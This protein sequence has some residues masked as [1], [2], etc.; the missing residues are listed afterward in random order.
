MIP[1]IFLPEVLTANLKR[2]ILWLLERQPS[3]LSLF[4]TAD[5]GWW[6][7][8]RRHRLFPLLYVRLLSAGLVEGVPKAV[9]QLLRHDY[10]AALH[11]FLGQERESRRLL[12]KLGDKGIEAI[13]LK[14]ADLRLRLYKDPAT[15]PMGDLDLLVS[16]VSLGAVRNLLGNLGYTLLL[17]RVNPRIGFGER[18]RVGLHFQASPPA[19]LMVDLHWG[20]EGVA[21][22]YRLPWARLAAQAQILDWEGI[23]FKVLSPEH[24]FMHLCLHHYDEGN[25]ALR[26][27]DLGLA[28]TRLPLNWQLFLTEAA[29]CR[30]QAPLFVMLRGLEELLPRAIPP[31]V[32]KELGAYVPRAV[33]RLVL[34]HSRHLLARLL[35]PLSHQRRPS[36]WAA[37]LA[38]YLWPDPAYLPMVSG[39]PSRLAYL[40]SSLK[41]LFSRRGSQ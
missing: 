28:L 8:L 29:Q 33:E 22:Y 7:E 36:A 35:G 4:R 16:P 19:S 27:V 24:A 40:A 10:L 9:A 20:L 38:S 12:T 14:G 32:L 37:Y 5:P 1:N 41:Y 21:G 18:Y 2:L 30:C 3:P 13:L 34:R 39:S 6:T 25:D 31:Q 17:C 15:R 11:L 26:L 23:S